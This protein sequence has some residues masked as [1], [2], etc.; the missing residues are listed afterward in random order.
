MSP[1]HWSVGNEVGGLAEDRIGGGRGRELDGEE[2]DL[3]P[4][5]R[6]H[7]RAERAGQQLRTEADAPDRHIRLDGLAEQPLLGGEPGV[8][9]LLVGAHGAAH[10][11]DR[12]K[13][14]PVGQRI[15]L[16]EL[17]PEELEPA[18][19]QLVLER[20]RRLAGD[21]LQDEEAR[22]QGHERYS[23]SDGGN[24]SSSGTSGKKR[25]L[26]SAIVARCRSESGPNELCSA[27]PARIW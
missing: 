21:V 18:R 5:A 22:V 23:G 11:D 13:L 14:P 6:V 15:A 1:C 7:P 24:R 2:A 27:T 12:R 16:V 10:H 25:A 9:V 3:G 17:D 4:L 19:A 8:L 26:S 20:G